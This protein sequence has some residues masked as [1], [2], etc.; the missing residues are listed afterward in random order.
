MVYQLRPYQKDAVHRV[1]RHFRKSDDPALMV[2]PTGAGKSLVISELARIARGRVLVL[3]HVKELVEQNHAKYQSYGLKASIFSAGLGQKEASEPV[4][5][6]SVQSVVRNLKQFQNVPDQKAFTLLVIDE[7]HRVSMEKT[8]SYHKVIEHFKRLNPNLKVLGLTAT[9]Y[10]LGMGWLYQYHQSA[11][12]KG[13]VRTEEP[14]FFKEC[15]FELPLSYMVD[16]GYLTTPEVVDAP[17]VFYDFSQ[18]S[19]DGF[20]RYGEQELNQLLKGKTRATREIINQVKKEAATRK[21]VMVFASTVDHAREIMGYLPDDE[22]ALIIGDTPAKERDRLIAAFKQQQLK[23]LVNVS[24]LT[25]GFDAP[26]VDLIAILRP[27]ESVSLYQQIAGRGLRLAPDK[28]DC[29]IIDYAG[30]R[31]SLYS[32]EVGEPKPD[33]KAVPVTVPCPACGHENHFWGVVDSDG[34]LVE[35]YGRRCQG[36]AMFLD[37]NGS[38]VKERCEFRYRFKQCDQCGAEN[39]IAARK[40]HSCQNG[41]VDPDKKLREALNLKNCLV[42]RCSGME[43]SADK[44]AQGKQ[45]I[46]ITYHD[47]DGAEVNEFFRLDTPSQQG[48]FYHHFG[49]HALINRAEPFRASTVD[50]VIHSRKKFRKPDFVI[51]QKEKQYWKIIDKLF[52]YDG[53]Y[54]KA[55]AL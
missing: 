30:N 26:H 55:E 35:H 51:A 36:F 27:T 34:D 14:R 16:N 47:E 31:F 2:L 43:M 8:S 37:D 15:L 54:R 22:S 12:N 6:G 38:E 32:P 52:D 33:S 28:K 25:T 45:R 39:D 49:K 40:C 7:C 23:F 10:R 41:L 24:V 4:I 53:K 3:A 18:L 19:R 48:A 29:L 21:G 17:I 44:D 13:A 46:R 5:F 50:N 20:G 1:I 9:P 42:I 11:E